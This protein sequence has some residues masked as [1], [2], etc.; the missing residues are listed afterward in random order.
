MLRNGS[1]TDMEMAANA[2]AGVLVPGSNNGVNNVQPI[3][4][5]SSP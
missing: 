3:S 5:G 1:V 2:D 4:V